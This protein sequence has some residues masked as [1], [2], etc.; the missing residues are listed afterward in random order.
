VEL[1]Q[2][3]TKSSVAKWCF[4]KLLND[5]PSL[6]SKHFIEPSAG[7]GEFYSLL[8]K[9]QRTGIDIQPMAEGI[10]QANFLE[11][12]A[13]LSD[14]SKYAIIGNPPFGHRSGMAIDF[15]NHS[16]E[17]ADTIAFIAPRQFQKYSVHS[18][19]NKDFRL[20]ADYELEENSF[21]T[22]ANKDFYA[23]CVFQIWTRDNTPNT[24]LRILIPP[25]TR[26]IDFD[27]Y[28]YNNTLQAR[29]VFKEDWDFGVPRQGYEDYSRREKEARKC[30]LRK[31]WILF[32]PKNQEIYKRLWN[33][34]FG[35]LA[36]K[37]TVIYGFGK[38]DVVMEYNRQYA[39]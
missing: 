36:K 17:I 5:L 13:P 7:N 20:I 21:Y 28:Q 11:W 3:Y 18:K 26:H 4:N 12:R 32:K 37:N 16:A 39:R 27:M 23:R 33:L 22:P 8:P 38:A 6:A 34:D 9:H 1:D 29:K 25:P 2:Y 19:L 10:K 24:N 30:E 31:Q 35:Q 14:K 15:F